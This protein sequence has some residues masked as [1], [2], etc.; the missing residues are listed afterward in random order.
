MF[1]VYNVLG[2][3]GLAVKLGISPDIIGNALHAFKKVPGRLEQ[4][5]MPNG[6]RCI[7]DYAHNP[8]SYQAVLSTLRT[9]TP[10]LIVVFGCGGN[11]DKSKRPLMGA[12]AT[13][14]ADLVVLTSDN[15][16]S[17]NPID[18]IVDIQQGIAT[19]HK[20]KVICELDREQAIKKAYQLSKDGSI[21]VLLGKGPDEYQMVGTV[22]TPFSESGIIKSLCI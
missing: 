17:E 1:N 7:I 19:E 20:Y 18:I 14:L 3:V 6:S 11:R 5:H 22:K 4:Y 16:R 21:I 15:P 12:I 2:V 10:H 9:L 8:S 13:E